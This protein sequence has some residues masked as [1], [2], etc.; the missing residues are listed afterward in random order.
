MQPNYDADGWLGAI[1]GTKIYYN[2]THL[3]QVENG[4][5]GILKE[6]KKL[7]LYKVSPPMT[8]A[9]STL[10]QIKSTPQYSQATPITSVH[11]M[12]SEPIAWSTEQ[13]GR[14]LVA[15]GLG[16]YQSMFMGQDINGRSLAYLAKSFRQNIALLSTHCV[17][18]E[19]SLSF[20]SSGD[21]LCFLFELE[22]LFF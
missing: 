18:V 20:K 15:I 16:H 22:N 6:L 10:T 11:T 9:N 5:K 13:V 19:G 8:E 7:D 14:W 1:M 21:Y 2:V 17:H 4:V 3:E 12:K